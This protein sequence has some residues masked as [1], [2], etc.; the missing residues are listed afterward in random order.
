VPRSTFEADTEESAAL[1][2]ALRARE[3]AA[4]RRA[5]RRLSPLVAALL[6]RYREL[7]CS[8]E[9]LCQ[10]VFQRFFARIDE[11]RDPSGL[12]GFVIGICLGVAQNERRRALIRQASAASPAPDDK[13]PE[14]PV[15]AADFEAREMLGRLRALLA[16]VDPQDADLFFMKYVEQ[17]E[18]AELASARGVSISTAKRH[19]ARAVQRIGTRMRDD[20][21]LGPLAERLA[22]RCAAR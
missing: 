10:E 15:M 8:R 16:A 1:V 12:R 5:W 4:A 7:A 21:G 14:L 17:M 22:G 3:P 11:L 9:D 6:R 18:F 13:P 20:P 19:L 2:A